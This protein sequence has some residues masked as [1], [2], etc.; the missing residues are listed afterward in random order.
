MIFALGFL[1][2]VEALKSLVVMT[3]V[4]DGRITAKEAVNCALLEVDYQTEQWGNVEWAHDLER[5][6]LLARTAAAVLMVRMTTYEEAAK[7]KLKQ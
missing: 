5:E 7:L 6:S 3:A 2:G 1:A 4:V